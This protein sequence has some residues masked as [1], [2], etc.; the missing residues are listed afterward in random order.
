M[1]R[2]LVVSL[3]VSPV[4]V[5]VTCLASPATARA[6]QRDEHG[7]LLAGAGLVVRPDAGDPGLGMAGNIEIGF[8]LRGFP[9]SIWLGALG[10]YEDGPTSSASYAAPAAI[11]GFYGGVEARTRGWIYLHGGAGLLVA[12]VWSRQIDEVPGTGEVEELRLTSG[13]GVGGVGVLGLGLD[14]RSFILRL[15]LQ[16]LGAAAEWVTAG[17]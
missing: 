13:A 2:S 9:I 11:A 4:L 12:G 16:V 15:D 10:G 5:L 7:F 6:E 17:G 14:I 3:V 1:S 8:P